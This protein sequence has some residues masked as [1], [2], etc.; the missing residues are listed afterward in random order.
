MKYI[1][2][3]AAVIKDNDKF[4]CAQRKDNKFEYLAFKFEFPGGKIEANET[5]EDCLRREIKEEL[6]ASIHSIS[7]LM[8][9]YHDYPDFSVHITFFECAIDK[10]KI[11]LL[12]HK[13]IIW[14]AAKELKTL[15]WAEAD[16][17]VVNLL[18]KQ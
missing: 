3:V 4:L 15:D 2:V 12:D 11:A 5:F 16:L 17:P 10:N 14:K 9:V 1:E 18:G 6:S 7:F 8:D 13:K